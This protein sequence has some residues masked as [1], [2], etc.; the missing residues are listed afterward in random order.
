M[1]WGQW[2]ELRDAINSL[3]ERVG[4]RHKK[5]DARGPA[6]WVGHLTFQTLDSLILSRVYVLNTHT[7]THTHTFSLSHTTQIKKTKPLRASEAG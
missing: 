2:P 4:P 5:T 6:A 1:G 3:V 7:P